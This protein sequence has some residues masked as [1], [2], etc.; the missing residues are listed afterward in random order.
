MTRLFELSCEK[1]N[2]RVLFSYRT[3]YKHLSRE[4]CLNVDL[5]T[6]NSD[7]EAFDGKAFK[8]TKGGKMAWATTISTAWGTYVETSSTGQKVAI[9]S[10][11]FRAQS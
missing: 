7:F 3:L 6:M 9:L 2:Y 11:L 4:L 10:G 8:V 5:A 1:E